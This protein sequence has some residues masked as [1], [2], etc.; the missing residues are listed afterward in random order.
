MHWR[1]F[2]NDDRKEWTRLIRGLFDKLASYT[3]PSPS[4]LLEVACFSK[5]MPAI[6]KIFERV[7][8]DPA[9]Q[10]ELMQPANRMGPLGHT[11]WRGDV[12]AL[13]EALQPVLLGIVRCCK[14]TS[15]NVKA[16]KR[17]LQH[18]QVTPGLIDMDELLA[19]VAGA[20]WPDMF[21]MLIEH[22]LDPDEKVFAA[23]A[24]C[25]SE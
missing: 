7:K 6:E 16:A 15:D 12:A 3:I 22:F 2:G 18:A 17:L 20:H 19:E 14:H 23:I 9:F 21:R 1:S 25:L 24:A 10:E 8:A 13:R 11:T 5:C 4:Y